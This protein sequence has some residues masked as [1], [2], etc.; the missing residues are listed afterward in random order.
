MGKENDIQNFGN[1]V[2]FGGLSRD[3]I[4]VKIFLRILRGD[5]SFFK[6]QLKMEKRKMRDQ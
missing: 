2:K 6:F 1:R 5:V 3:E 4:R